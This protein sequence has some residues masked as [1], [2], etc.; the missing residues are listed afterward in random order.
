MISSA[1]EKENLSVREAGEIRTHMTP[2]EA[3]TVCPRGPLPPTPSPHMPAAQ[4]PPGAQA[5]GPCTHGEAGGS[6]E[7]PGPRRSFCECGRVPGRMAARGPRGQQDSSPA[8][9]LPHWRSIQIRNQRSTSTQSLQ[10]CDLPEHLRRG[11]PA[12]APPPGAPQGGPVTPASG[13]ET[14]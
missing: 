9:R 4:T 7:G 2:R 11:R 14:V 6:R 13:E 3:C 12:S 10:P 5:K 8:H 1:L